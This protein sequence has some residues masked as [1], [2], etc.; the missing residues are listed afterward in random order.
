VARLSSGY[1]I[2]TPG[3]AAAGLGVGT[4]LEAPITSYNQ[5]VRN[6]N[7]GVSVVQTAEAGLDQDSAI[8]TRLRELAMEF[9]SGGMGDSDRAHVD[10]GAQQLTRRTGPRP[11]AF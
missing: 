7:D 10:A 3:D 2:T 9:A 1:R 8:L 5:A 6:A 11:L 4:E